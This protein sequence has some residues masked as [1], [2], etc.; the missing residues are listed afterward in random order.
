MGYYTVIFGL[1][2]RDDNMTFREEVHKSRQ[3]LWQEM[4]LKQMGGDLDTVI[5]RLDD[6]EATVI[7]KEFDIVTRLSRIEDELNILKESIDRIK[8]SISMQATQ[9]PAALPPTIPEEV[10]QDA[11]DL[12]IVTVA[13]KKRELAHKVRPMTESKAQEN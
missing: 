11:I 1:H 10:L 12:F 13:E 2:N 9:A 3:K 8:F 5:D 6:I 4:D 7:S